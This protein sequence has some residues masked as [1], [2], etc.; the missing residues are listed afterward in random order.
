MSNVSYTAFADSRL[1]KNGEFFKPTR[2]LL[3]LISDLSEINILL[4]AVGASQQTTRN[5]TP[6]DLSRRVQF[7][8][9]SLC[10]FNDCFLY[11]RVGK[12][13]FYVLARTKQH[14]VNVEITNLRTALKFELEP[15]NVAVVTCLADTFIRSEHCSA[16]YSMFCNF[17]D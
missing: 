6:S 2:K 8:T 7:R 13:Q 15:L 9:I 16:R 3:L 14:F 12:L 17:P 10:F 1:R 11:R 5:G 4:L